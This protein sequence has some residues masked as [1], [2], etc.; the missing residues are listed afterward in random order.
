MKREKIANGCCNLHNLSKIKLTLLYLL[1]W[2][3]STMIFQK[4]GPWTFFCYFYTKY[5]N[6]QKPYVSLSLIMEETQTFNLKTLIKTFNDAMMTK[7]FSICVNESKTLSKDWVISIRKIPNFHKMMCLCL[8]FWFNSSKKFQK[9]PVCS[10]QILK[11]R[12]W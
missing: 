1:L 3:L 12:I 5:R 6:K 9:M 2:M 11:I 4:Y 7:L 8:F 10:I